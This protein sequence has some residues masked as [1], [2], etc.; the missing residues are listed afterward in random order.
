MKQFWAYGSSK[1]TFSAVCLHF[2]LIV[3]I[4]LLQTTHALLLT[5]F[6]PKNLDITNTRVIVRNIMSA[7]SV[8]RF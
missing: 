5:L 2:Q 3:Y 4:F 1:T 6:A 7:F 8:D